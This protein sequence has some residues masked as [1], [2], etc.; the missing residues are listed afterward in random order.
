MR[1]QADDVK[2]LGLVDEARIESQLLDR[3]ADLRPEKIVLRREFNNRKLYVGEEPR[4][5]DEAVYRVRVIG[6]LEDLEVEQNF[7]H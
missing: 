7:S 2:E 1:T 6:K 5:V 4:G 3:V